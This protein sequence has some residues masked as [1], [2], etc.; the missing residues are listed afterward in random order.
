MFKENLRKAAF[1]VI[2]LAFFIV[3]WA[4][5][6]VRN[7]APGIA[8][9]AGIIFAVSW[10]NPFA[11]LTGKE[12]VLDLYCGTGTIGL[13][14]AGEAKKVLGVEIVP[15]AVE[16]AK[17]NAAL[18]G[19]EVTPLKADVFDLLTELTGKKCRDYDYVILD[20]PPCSLLADASEIAEVADCGLLVVRHDFASKSQIIDGAQRLTDAGLPLIGCVFNSVQMN[21]AG[22]Y[23]YGYG[24]GYGGYGKY[25]SYGAETEEIV[26]TE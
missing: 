21:L 10:G 4:V 17:V 18:N 7:Y 26:E 23:G 14:M 1:I 19:L 12:R 6:Q 25:G 15:D 13:S 3:P 22:R 16:N 24:Y 5:P 20:T 9:F 11:E 8:V 2:A